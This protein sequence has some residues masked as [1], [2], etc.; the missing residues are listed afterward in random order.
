MHYNFTIS[1][2]S[3]LAS[4]QKKN[5]LSYKIWHKKYNKEKHGMYLIEQFYIP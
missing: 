2:L 1:F 3:F 4:S 5:A